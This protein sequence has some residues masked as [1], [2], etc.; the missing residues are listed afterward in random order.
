MGPTEKAMGPTEKAMGPTEKAMGPTE[1]ATTAAMAGGAI[2]AAMEDKA[3]PLT[4]MVIGTI[5]LVI[6]LGFGITF[7]RAKQYGTTQNDDSPPEPGVPGKPVEKRR[8]A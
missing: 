4:Y 1:K 6:V 2:M 5:V 7:S 8:T 3:T